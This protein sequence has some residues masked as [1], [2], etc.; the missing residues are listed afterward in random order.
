M[1]EHLKNKGTQD[2]SFRDRI[3]QDLERLKQE[4]LSRPP[5]EKT[6]EIAI[7]AD[8]LS[9]HPDSEQAGD[10]V[11]RE[12][13][14]FD[15]P[16]KENQVVAKGL[17]DRLSEEVLV[18]KTG[19]QADV[20]YAEETAPS[21]LT[22][23][24]E[25]TR[26]HQPSEGDSQKSQDNANTS[27][28]ESMSDDAEERSKYTRNRTSSKRQQKKKEKTTARNMRMI[29]AGVLCAVIVLGATGYFYVKSSLDPVNAKATKTIQVTIPEGSTRVEV[30]KI[31]EKNHLIKNAAIFNYYT[32]LKNYNNF[33]S[34]SFNLSQSMSVDALSRALQ[35]RDSSATQTAGKILV[36]EGSTIKQIAQAVTNNVNS[37]QKNNKTKFSSEEFLKVI[38][39]E[40]FI[41]KMVAAYPQ[42]FAKLPAADSGVLYRLEGYLF[43]ATY[44]Y[45]ESTT[46]EQLIE[47]MIA[48]MNEQLTPYY[49]Q[50]EGKGLDVNALLSIASLVE[51]EAATDEDR[52]TVAS[53]FYNR[54]NAGMPLQSNIAILYA[55]GKLG[56]KTT[57]S[58]DAA[59]DTAIDSPYNIYTHAGLTPGPVTSP[60]K[61]A[62]DAA[63]NPNKTNYYYFVADVKTGT[64]YFSETLEEHE[65]N[66]ATY[67]NSQIN[68]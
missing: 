3:L 33:Q 54:I 18:G 64:V 14:S 68:N 22:E 44:E 37:K 56:E 2:L 53:V 24:I 25:D 39:D 17:G 20:S 8:E 10:T 65:K 35:V 13:A 7:S 60:S 9:R 58:E 36:V 57:L 42:L 27:K 49:D 59:I 50:L 67:V 51:K 63:I 31:L 46:M 52:R 40:N 38:T 47:Q 61:S 5:L 43:P 48:T 41:N 55:M 1:A 45:T 16:K 15:Y 19:L 6:D 4:R 11:V 26:I 29:V 28:E 30:G 21:P 12:T 66:V 34:G 23:T 62:I 32:K